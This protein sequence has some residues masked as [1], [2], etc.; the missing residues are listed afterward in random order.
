VNKNRSRG[1]L[2]RRGFL[3]RGMVAVAAGSVA[4]AKEAGASAARSG[5][6]PF[7]LEEVTIADL[8]RAMASGG[9]TSVSITE[10]YLARIEAI[11]KGGPKINAVIEIN[12]DALAIA[13]QRDEERRTHGPRGPMHG[14]PI[15]IK[16]NIGTHDRMMTTAGSLALLGSVPPEDAFVV[17]RLR[18]AGAV[19]IAK[20]NLSEWADV[21]SSVST[22]GWS[23]RGGQTNNPYVLDRT[24]GGSSAGTGA[25][26]AASLAAVGLGSETDGSILVPSAQNSLVGIKP[27]VG[28]VSRTGV[29]PISHSQDTVGPMGRTVA[30]VAATLGAMTGVDPKDPVSAGSRGRAYTDYTQ[31][32]DPAGLKGARI[33]VARRH[34]D[35]GSAVDKVLQNAIDAIRH[36]G[37]E[38]IDPTDL[39]N[40][41]QF[42][43][44]EKIILL[45]ELKAGMNAY[46]QGLGP[47]APVH[48]LQEIIE[49]NEKNWRREM[50]YFG[51]DR[52]IKAQSYGDLATPEYLTALEKCHRLTR[53]EGIDATIDKFRL[54]ALVAATTGPAWVTDLVTGDHEADKS[55]H[56][57]AIAGYPNIT[58]PAGYIFGLPVGVC[59]FGKAYTEP[60]LLKLAFA[61]EQA[62]HHRRPPQ[63][64]PTANL[65]A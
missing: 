64:L 39:D 44:N 45:Y 63:F 59:F 10:K 65:N 38:V 54:D 61:F 29:I 49:F 57:T 62:T 47:N 35:L 36:A 22:T 2:D 26:I 5:I 60:T 42:R 3:E 46:L 43:P 58:V 30:D 50:P 41:E 31:F 23:A 14:I 40:V 55:T 4:G 32:L 8:Q 34:V 1:A 21:R 24:P 13:K 52:F 25:G 53:A 15:L 18:E 27:T 6:S 48:T 28:L 37:A 33:G 12:P 17:K 19:I 20:A 16:D 56:P 9:A 7:E 11:D 51:Q